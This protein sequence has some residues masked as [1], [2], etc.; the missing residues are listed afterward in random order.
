V[1]PHVILLKT[2]LCWFS[3]LLDLWNDKILYTKRNSWGIET[4]VQGCVGL[5]H[6]KWCRQRSE[7]LGIVEMD[8]FF[9]L[10]RGLRVQLRLHQSHGLLCYRSQLDICQFDIAFTH[11]RCSF[12]I[13][14]EKGSRGWRKWT[15]KELH[16]PFLDQHF[17]RSSFLY[18]CDLEHKITENLDRSYRHRIGLCDRHKAR[19]GNT[20]PYVHIRPYLQHALAIQLY[21]RVQHRHNHSWQLRFV[22]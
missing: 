7:W 2:D 21:L 18:F 6:A 4:W 14:E 9:E 16:L 19:L 10:L 3:T 15:Y 20:R 5:I 13:F 12:C 8:T 22:A 17:I 11:R 1:C